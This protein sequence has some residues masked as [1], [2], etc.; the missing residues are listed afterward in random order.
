MVCSC[1]HGQNVEPV[2]CS[3]CKTTP[4]AGSTACTTSPNPNKSRQATT[5]ACRERVNS[6]G[7]VPGHRVGQDGHQIQPVFYNSCCCRRRGRIAH[8]VKIC[9]AGKKLEIKT[10]CLQ[11]PEHGCVP[12]SPSCYPAHLQTGES[13]SLLNRR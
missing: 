11:Q 10:A 7:T 8:E 9:I 2:S 5:T 4:P 6:G 13:G 12:S 3:S 1:S